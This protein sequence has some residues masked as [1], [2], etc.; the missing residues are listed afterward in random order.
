[1]SAGEFPLADV[2]G[3]HVSITSERLLH[4]VQSRLHGDRPA[5]APKLLQQAQLEFPLVAAAA[6]SKTRRGIDELGQTSP[7]FNHPAAQSIVKLDKFRRTIFPGRDLAKFINYTGSN[8]RKVLVVHLRYGNVAEGNG[9]CVTFLF[10]ESGT[11]TLC[12]ELDFASAAVDKSLVEIGGR[13]AGEGF[14]K[15]FKQTPFANIK[16]A[17]SGPGNP[18]L[19]RLLFIAVGIV[20]VTDLARRGRLSVLEGSFH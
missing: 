14:Q 11:D 6:E 15:Q 16:A 12:A 10:L 20:D 18:H 3:P 17:L 13:V 1:M 2:L 5:E 8:I 4:E 7:S 9:R 19:S